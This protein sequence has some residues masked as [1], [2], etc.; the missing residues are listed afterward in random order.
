MS[1]PELTPLNDFIASVTLTDVDAAGEE[2]PVIAGTVTAVFATSRDSDA[3]A[4]DPTL[5]TSATYTGA[6]GV[7]LIRFDAATLTE[8][9]LDTHF[10]SASPYLIVQMTG[11]VR[12]WKRC[13]YVASRAAG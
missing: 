12:V 6:G 2:T 5:S 11:A 8:S 10:A 9:L 4:A 7:W 1:L 3:T 13:K